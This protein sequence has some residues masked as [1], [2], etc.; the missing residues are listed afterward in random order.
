M[1][2]GRNLNEYLVEDKSYRKNDYSLNNL[3]S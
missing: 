2:K 1:E 3:D